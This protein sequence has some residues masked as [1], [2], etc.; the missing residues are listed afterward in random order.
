MILLLFG[1]ITGLICGVVSGL[2]P[3]IHSNTMAG[4][5]VGISPAFIQVLGPEGFAAALIS[6]LI[7]H[8]FLELIPSTFFG[9]PDSGTALSVLPAHALTLE[10]RGEEA[11]RLSALGCLYG[12]S[13]GVPISILAFLFLSPVQDSIDWITGPLLVLMMGSVII[14]EESPL[15][16]LLIFAGSGLL[17]LFA[18]R[19]Q[20]LVWGFAGESSILMPLL[21]GLFGLSVILTSSHSPIPRQHFNGLGL[22][23]HDVIRASIPG[24]LAGLFVGW[25]PGLSTASANAVVS[26]GIRYDTN[27]RSYLVASGAATCANVIVGLAAF[28]G[29]G[30]TRNGVMVAISSLV[31]P[32]F[33]VL[34]TIAVAAAGLAYLITVCLSG[35]ARWVSGMNGRILNTLV[36][37]FVILLS[38]IF[39]G[40]FGLFILV[41]ATAIG[42]LP[43]LLNLSR[44]TCMGAVTLPV[45]LYS[46]GLWG[47]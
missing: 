25:L 15:W 30:R 32:S 42:F 23:S 33:P 28:Y 2:I 4:I 41:C 7:S 12:V 29:I 11:V 14:H 26:A 38:G 13:I 31:P 1:T 36:G 47:F 40:P 5:M 45:I 19:Y 22:E 8:S 44:V 35:Y 34:L 6:L 39:T 17:G 21:T 24:A 27:Q 43:E 16:A 9:I 18:F 46:L 10:G 20:F 37:G 3:G